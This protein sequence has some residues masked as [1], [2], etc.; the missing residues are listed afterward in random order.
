MKASASHCVLISH[1]PSS[2]R[3]RVEESKALGSIGVLDVVASADGLDPVAGA[4]IGR[5]S[6]CVVFW[7]VPCPFQSEEVGLIGTDPVAAVEVEHCHVSEVRRVYIVA[8]PREPDDGSQPTRIGPAGDRLSEPDVGDSGLPRG[9]LSR[10][11]TS[12]SEE[13]FPC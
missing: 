4:Q 13:V 3:N 6:D 10:E 9:G 8:E 7:K 11:R 12:K 1:S 5:L 2:V